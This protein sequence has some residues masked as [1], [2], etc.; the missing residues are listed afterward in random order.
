MLQQ[1]AIRAFVRP[2]GKAKGLFDGVSI[3]HFNAS[4]NL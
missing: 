2:G 3:T 1:D 4:R